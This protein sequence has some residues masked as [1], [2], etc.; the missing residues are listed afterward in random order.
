MKNQ[1]ETILKQKGFKNKEEFYSM[2]GK[3]KVKTLYERICYLDWE[4]R[5]G[6]K[7]GLEKLIYR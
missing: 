6:S 7:Q 5:D 4:A 1:S 3:I 2:V